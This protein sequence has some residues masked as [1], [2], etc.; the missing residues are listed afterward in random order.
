M[1]TIPAR[2]RRRLLLRSFL[3]QGSWNYE[4]LIG[5]GFAFTLIPLLRFLHPDDAGARR[6]ALKRH[7]SVFNSHPYLAPL[8]VGAVARLE[9]DGADPVMMERFKSALRGSLGSLGDRLVWSA[10]RPA[11]ILLGLVLLLAGAAW[12]VAVV[13]FLLVY[14]VFHLVLRAWG[15]RVGTE[16]GI[17]V[18]KVLRSVP[19][20][21]IISWI[22]NA[23]AMLGGAALVLAIAPAGTGF[24]LRPIALGVGAAAVGLWLGLRARRVLAP[25]V[26]I[27]WVIAI[28]FGLMN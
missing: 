25:A 8:A 13:A 24:E 2:V 5:T 21:A 15:L 14:N 28:A 26:G 16:S 17:E 4:T 7:S 10:W 9:A 12:W 22:G 19:F 6:E 18:G 20:E 1:T 23:G 3:V 11:S 27:A